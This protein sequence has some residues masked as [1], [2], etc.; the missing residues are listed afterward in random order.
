MGKPRNYL[1]MRVITT[2]TF[3]VQ[4]VCYVTAWG[5]LSSVIVSETVHLLLSS[6]SPPGN[7]KKRQIPP[8]LSQ[9]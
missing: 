9:F 2:M 7:G 1:K 8:N 6:I 4:G 3:R 5:A